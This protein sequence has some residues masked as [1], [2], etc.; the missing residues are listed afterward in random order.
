LN[1][2]SSRTQYQLKLP[3][4]ICK[5]IFY[6][7]ELLNQHYHFIHEEDMIK[8]VTS[9]N[10][11]NTY[12]GQRLPVDING[13]SKYTNSKVL[14]KNKCV[15]DDLI[16]CKKQLHDTN[17]STEHQILDQCKRERTEKIFK[18][19][20]GCTLNNRRL[21]TADESFDKHLTTSDLFQN[22]DRKD[23]CTKPYKCD[24]CGKGFSQNGNLQTHIRTHTADKPYKCDR[25]GKGFSVNSNLQKHIR[26]HTGDKP[27]KCDICGKGFSQNGDLQTHIRTHTGDKP[28]K[29]DI[30]GKGF[31]QNGDLQKHI[32][33][34]TAVKEIRN[35]NP[36]DIRSCEL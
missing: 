35:L 23:T 25:C 3:C 11:C 2:A 17:S 14:L 4:T 5:K 12:C 6:S 7:E 8:T 16:D 32:R 1:P 34:H 13:V 10:S 21:P 24:I 29:C 22:Y 36:Q 26:T 15:M 18:C 27:Y 9:Q 31:S 33:T 28:Y 20:E 30:C 19:G